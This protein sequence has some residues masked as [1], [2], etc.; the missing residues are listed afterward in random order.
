[1]IDLR[2]AEFTRP[3]TTIRVNSWI[4]T[5][6]VV[7]P[8]DVEVQVSGTGILGGFHQDREN[9]L[10]LSARINVKGIAVIGSVHVVH[11]LPASKVR[12]LMKIKQKSGG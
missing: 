10:R 11:E 6:Y 5:V 4:S 2:K 1:M 7:V 12:R 3:E 9:G 8:E